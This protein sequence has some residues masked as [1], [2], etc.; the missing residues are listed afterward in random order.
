M[1][2]NAFQTTEADDDVVKSLR[3]ALV[4]KD[5]FIQVRKENERERERERERASEREKKKKNLVNLT[6]VELTSAKFTKA[7]RFSHHPQ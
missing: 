3:E 7:Q 2:I 4:E 1:S 6:S 5:K